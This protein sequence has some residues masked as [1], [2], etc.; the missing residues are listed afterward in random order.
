[1]MEAGLDLSPYSLHILP[2][3]CVYY[4]TCGCTDKNDVIEVGEKRERRIGS[5]HFSSPDAYYYGPG[6]GLDVGHT[7][8]N[9][10]H[11]LPWAAHSL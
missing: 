4:A 3:L 7:K 2:S 1:M 5:F 10:V 6:P 9:K 8:M 11:P